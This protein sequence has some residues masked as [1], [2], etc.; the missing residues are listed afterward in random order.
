[1]G[2]T[3]QGTLSSNCNIIGTIL[4][5]YLDTLIGKER[6]LEDSWGSFLYLNHEFLLNFTQMHFSIYSYDLFPVNL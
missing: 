1:M 3:Y 4:E 5:E 6:H 2:V